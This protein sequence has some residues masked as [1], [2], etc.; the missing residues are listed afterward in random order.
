M[1]KNIGEQQTPPTAQGGD[2]GTQAIKELLFGKFTPVKKMTRKELSDEVEMWRN[3]WQWIPSE[4][5]YYVSRTGQ[6]IGVQIRNYQR[7]VGPLLDTVWELKAIE[8][9]VYDKMFNQ[10]DGEYYYERKIS[11]LPIGQIVAFDWIAERK[12]QKEMEQ[13]IEEQEL[14][15]EQEAEQP[16]LVEEEEKGNHDIDNE[17]S[18]LT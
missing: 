9:G 14:Q 18:T 16:D 2:T 7:Y 6:T 12:S 1:T 3:I 11:R 15:K 4:I 10:V 13:L 17:S 8:I 5:K